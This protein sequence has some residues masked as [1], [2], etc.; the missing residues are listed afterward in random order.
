MKIVMAI[1]QLAAS[2]SRLAGLAATGT[3][4]RALEG[5]ELEYSSVCC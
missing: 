2:P 3:S 1:A 4:G 5:G